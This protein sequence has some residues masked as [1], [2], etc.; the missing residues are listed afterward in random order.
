MNSKTVAQLIETLHKFPQDIPVV[1]LWDSGWCAITDECL[2][3]LNQSERTH[4]LAGDVLEI[5]VS[6][7][8]TYEP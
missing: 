4:A 5:D 8:G 3:V 6:E 1:I 2:S 7:Y